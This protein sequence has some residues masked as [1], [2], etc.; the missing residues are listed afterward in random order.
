V[1]V[2]VVV[3]VVVL[4]VVV[5]VVVVAAVVL[6]LVVVVV[7]VVVELDIVF[8]RFVLNGLNDIYKETQNKEQMTARNRGNQKKGKI[9]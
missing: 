5:V 6:V 7:V 9:N 2:V 4:V 1:V 8:V 3:V